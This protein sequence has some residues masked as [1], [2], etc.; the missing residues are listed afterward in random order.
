MK[1]RKKEVNSE[2]EFTSLLAVAIDACAAA[3]ALDYIFRL[4]DLFTV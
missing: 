4:R 3:N 1:F 2:F